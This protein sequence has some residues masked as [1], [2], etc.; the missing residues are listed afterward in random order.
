MAEE[1]SGFNQQ[2]E[3]ILALLKDTADSN[4]KDENLV[5]D[6][7]KNYQRTDNASTDFLKGIAQRNKEYYN[8]GGSLNP[9][10]R[11]AAMPVP[12]DVFNKLK[13]AIGELLILI[14]SI[15]SIC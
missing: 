5:I 11:E 1:S 8:G 12:E 9:S 4:S 14:E 15:K 7:K 13:V 2:Y 3:S 10:F 6:A